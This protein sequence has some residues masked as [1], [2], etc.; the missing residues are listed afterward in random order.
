MTGEVKLSDKPDALCI[1]ARSLSGDALAK[2]EREFLR[3]CEE[4]AAPAPARGADDVRNL[5]PEEYE[6]RLA[7]FLSE[8][9]E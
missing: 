1:D 9:G 6:R 8:N 2:A 5:S 3:L 4:G 7:T